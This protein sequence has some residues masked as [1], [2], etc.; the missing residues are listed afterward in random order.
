[1]IASRWSWSAALLGIAA[2]GVTW[3][4]RHGSTARPVA[5]E[6]PVELAVPALIHVLGLE[7]PPTATPPTPPAG[8][9]RPVPCS[10]LTRPFTVEARDG[11]PVMC[12]AGSCLQFDL[13]NSTSSVV[14]PPPPTV[15]LPTSATVLSVAGKWSACRG[16]T[17]KP[18]GR[19]LALALD[20]V[21]VND[22]PA[23]TLDLTTVVVG[24]Q[25]WNVATDRTVT[26]RR[27]EVRPNGP[28][29]EVTV[30]GDVLLVAWQGSCT[31]MMCLTSQLVDR[32]GHTLGWVQAG[33][34][35]VRLDDQN[36]MTIS[37]FSV[38]DIRDLHSGAQ[39]SA[40]D[41]KSTEGDFIAVS[42]LDDGHYAL[43]RM[44][45]SGF[46]ITV[47]DVEGG[48]ARID[49]AREMTVPDCD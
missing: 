6:P 27:P 10:N 35:V 22:K 16:D 11:K 43:V 34:R 15:E 40:I 4:V 37:E 30:I 42:R 24:D 23:A 2:L 44:A 39:V 5:P 13:E 18:V 12:A 21:Q 33:G 38:V 17:C 1:M 19:R 3:A 14:A 45:A 32:D 49:H 20:H 29:R 8:P 9:M 28:D 26:L 48:D 31:D 25:I 41:P 7:A 47:L 36:F 46:A